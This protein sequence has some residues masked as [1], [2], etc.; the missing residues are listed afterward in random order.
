MMGDLRTSRLKGSRA[1]RT[2]QPFRQ[3]LYSKTGANA[4]KNNYV[5]SVLCNR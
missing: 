3:A 2:V 4:A 5:G 1:K